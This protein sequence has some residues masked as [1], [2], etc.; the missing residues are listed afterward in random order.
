MRRRVGTAQEFA[1]VTISYRAKTWPSSIERNY[2]SS[3]GLV[4]FLRPRRGRVDS[5]GSTERYPLASMREPPRARGGTARSLP[6]RPIALGWQRPGGRRRL[7]C[8]AICRLHGGNAREVRITNSDRLR[9]TEFAFNGGPALRVFRCLGAPGVGILL[10]NA[11]DGMSA[12]IG[13]MA[14][15]E[16]LS[17]LGKQWEEIVA[18]TAGPGTY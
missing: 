16:Q 10:E 12:V 15:R 5:S 9:A 13:S 8:C 17:L 1:P 11:I 3:L 2:S 6:N 4:P 14:P 18:A 7:P